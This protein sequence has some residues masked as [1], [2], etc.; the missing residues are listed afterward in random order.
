MVSETHLFS[1]GND[2]QISSA[3][4]SMH[5]EAFCKDRAGQGA[6]ARAGARGRALGRA[7][8][9]ARARAIQSQSLM[10]TYIIQLKSY[11]IVL[12]STTS[13]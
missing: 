4:L 1:V 3:I 5:T 2:E 9:R 8:A 12:N 6:R 13:S 11:S 10:L 7:R